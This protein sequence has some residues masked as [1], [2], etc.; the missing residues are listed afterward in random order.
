MLLKDNHFAVH[1]GDAVATSCAGKVTQGLFKVWQ[2]DALLH[3]N[4]EAG[5][6]ADLMV[7]DKA[8]TALLNT[9]SAKADKAIERLGSPHEARNMSL[10]TC[11]SYLVD[12]SPEEW[13]AVSAV[14]SDLEALTRLPDM[15]AICD[16]L[17]RSRTFFV[18]AAE[19]LADLGER[20]WDIKPWIKH[21]STR[22][23][24]EFPRDNLVLVIYALAGFA[25]AAARC[26]Q[27]RSSRC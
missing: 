23:F 1:Q 16:L 12:P 22:G 6:L 26:E 27:S 7:L 25:W 24:P 21:E 20:G 3:V 8:P 14:V 17:F 13:Q 15:Q 9:L 5:S 19:A 11:M 10:A 4:Y 2:L 18:E